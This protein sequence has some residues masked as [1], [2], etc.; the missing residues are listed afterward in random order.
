MGFIGEHFLLTKHFLENFMMIG[1]W[2][3]KNVFHGSG[4]CRNVKSLE[5]AK[6]TELEPSDCPVDKKN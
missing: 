4:Y 1:I 2:R 6:V 5:Y 3:K